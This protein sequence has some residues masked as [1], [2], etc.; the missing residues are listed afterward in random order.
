MHRLRIL[1]SFWASTLVDEI[2][3]IASKDKAISKAK[4]IPLVF[5]GVTALRPLRPPRLCVPPAS[6][7]PWYTDLSLVLWPSAKRGDWGERRHGGIVGFLLMIAC[8]ILPCSPYTVLGVSNKCEEGTLRR[9]G[10]SGR[11]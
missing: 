6:R 2:C 1:I 5:F 9:G 3:Q 7:A 11:D 4:L 8:T 10:R